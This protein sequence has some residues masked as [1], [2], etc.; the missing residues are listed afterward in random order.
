MFLAESKTK[1]LNK[2]KSTSDLMRISVNQRQLYLYYDVSERTCLYHNSYNNS[3][4][5]TVHD[6]TE[7]M[8][9]KVPVGNSSSI[10]VKRGVPFVRPRSE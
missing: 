10:T 8:S 1:L 3:V 9:P 6:P 7:S 4:N 2:E 5:Y